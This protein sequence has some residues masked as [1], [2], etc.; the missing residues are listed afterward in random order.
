MKR[1][2]SINPTKPQYITVTNLSYAQIDYWFGHARMDL[3][4]DIIFQKNIPKRNILVLYGYVVAV[5]FLWINLFIWLI[6]QSLL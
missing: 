1:T 2:I 4:L 6:F 3:K 5:G